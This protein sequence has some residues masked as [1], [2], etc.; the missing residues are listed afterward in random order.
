MF[1]NQ[2]DYYRL[3]GGRVKSFLLRYIPDGLEKTVK[4]QAGMAGMGILNK[5]L[6][7]T[8]YA[9]LDNKQ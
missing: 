3:T 5:T 6:H 2:N 1:D 4:G 7:Y 8:E 9:L